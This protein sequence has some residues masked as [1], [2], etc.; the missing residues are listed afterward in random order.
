MSKNRQITNQK[1][2]KCSWIDEEGNISVI[3]Y[4]TTNKPQD[5]LFDVI[6]SM[7]VLYPNIFKQYENT[8]DNIRNWIKKGSSTKREHYIAIIG[9]QT[10]SVM[11]MK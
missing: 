1:K 3:N 11:E 9:E 7:L 8:T 4:K 2:Y 10:L 5:F 6:C